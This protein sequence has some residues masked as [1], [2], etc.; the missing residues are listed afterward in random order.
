MLLED[1]QLHSVNWSELSRG[2]TFGV[3]GG[4]LVE[5]IE[6]HGS[7]NIVTVSIASGGQIVLEAPLGNATA[8][9]TPEF[10]PGDCLPA[11]WKGRMR[12]SAVRSVP[13]GVLCDA[14]GQ[15]TFAFAFDCLTQEGQLEFGASEE[16]KT[17]VARLGITQ[18][19]AEA[20]STVRL[21]VVAP[22]T[23]Y[24]EAIRE[25]SVFLHGGIVGK[26][27][28]KIAREPVFSTWY[29]YSQQISH[30]IVMRNVVAA[31]GIG[32]KSV[33]IDDGWQKFGDGRW[34][35]GCGD[36]IPDTAKFPDLRGTVAELHDAGL[37]TVLWVAPFLVGELS[38]AHA[39]LAPFASHYSE[40]LRTW[41]LDPR[42]SEVREHLVGICTRLMADYALDGLKIDFLNSVMAYAGTNST[43]DIA[44][45]GDAMV[46]V[47]GD[48][49]AAVEIIRP[50]ALIEFRQPYI[51]PAIAPFADVLRADDCPADADQNRRST[52]N[53][54]LLAIDRTIH[55]DPVMWDPT[56][57]VETVSRQLLNVFF[58]VPQISMPLDV[59]PDAH[60]V[61][62]TE[63]LAE[64]RSLR[65]VLL[66]GELSVGLPN[67]SY[68]VV[69]SRLGST[70]V[71]ALYQPRQLELDLEGISELVILNSTASPV[72]PYV[73]DGSSPRAATLLTEG[74]AAS[75][76]E[77]GT[78]GFLEVAPW[79]ITRIML[80]DKGRG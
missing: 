34:Y 21:A 41:V 46:Q 43:G 77:L 29:A 19:L 54:R 50:G 12:F 60:R 1:H 58:S 13:I 59:L 40:V 79:G 55:S 57:P 36:W 75:I 63:L 26:P 76:I 37:E 25:L 71:V 74:A 17:F 27:A 11:D 18:G 52:I 30:E 7:L 5:G 9:W 70:L 39:A 44:D 48:I 80:E 61:R 49:A 51:S 24:E 73:I 66:T 45:V 68:P 8:Y 65:E 42:H 15:S 6:R 56:A 64:W 78:C 67:E 28:S 32:C 14:N 20:R 23:G 38:A 4:C 72:L 62:A 2:I 10:D 22:E 47:L 16:A 53:L 3:S 69:S 35:A 31:R 33:F